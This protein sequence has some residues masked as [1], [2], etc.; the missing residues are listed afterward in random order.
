VSR[1]LWLVVTVLITSSPRSVVLWPDYEILSHEAAV[2]FVPLAPVLGIAWVE[3][4]EDTN[5]TLRAHYCWHSGLHSP[6]CEVG[7]FQIK[8]S[9][10]KANCPGL[11]IFTTIGNHTCFFHMFRANYERYGI[12][13][14]VKM[15]HSSP[16][17]SE[18]ELY[19]AK[20]KSVVTAIGMNQIPI[21][22]TCR[23]SGEEM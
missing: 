1:V 15:H 7:R 10:A 4:R 23:H 6:D 12:D 14:A 8:P 18:N 11:N 19:L 20:V 5:P 16:V 2:T 3:S 13:R 9:T 21:L 22:T 17:P